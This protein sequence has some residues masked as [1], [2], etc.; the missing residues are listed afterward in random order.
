MYHP[1]ILQ[2]GPKMR[3]SILLYINFKHNTPR[4]LLC[5]QNPI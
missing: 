2:I 3:K 1:L 5:N 4:S